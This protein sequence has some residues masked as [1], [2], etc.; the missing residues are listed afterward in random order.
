MDITVEP[1]ALPGVVIVTPKVIRDPRGFF[2]E[3]FNR[4]EF[5]KHGLSCDFVQD[6]HSRSAQKVVR[7]LHFQDMRAPMVKLVR[8]T[9]GAILDVAV[10]VRTG[11]PTYG[12]W[13][14]VELNADNMK[15]LLVPVG[16]AHGF[17]TLSDFA[18]V[19]YK[20]STFYAPETEGCIA[21]NDPDIGIDWPFADPILSKRDAAAITLQAYS[22]QPAFVYGQA[23]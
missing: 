6:N 2:T 1:T 14:A 20:C 10:D 19:Q 7:G 11:S 23:Q 4:R 13:V 5:E 17:A 21:W 9:A 18:E 12:R 8:C 16:F 15:Q 22:K 3:S